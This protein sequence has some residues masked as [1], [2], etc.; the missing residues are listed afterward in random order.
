MHLSRTR[1]CVVSRG[2]GVRVDATASDA[3]DACSRRRAEGKY[4]TNPYLDR[5]VF[6]FGLRA[7]L[8]SLLARPLADFEGTCKAPPFR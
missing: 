4:T 7:R 6:G 5:R 8:K 3:I 1:I 2:D